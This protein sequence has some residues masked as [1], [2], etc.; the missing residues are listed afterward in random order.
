[1]V[2][3]FSTHPF[4]LLLIFWKNLFF[5]VFANSTKNTLKSISRPFNHTEKEIFYHPIPKKSRYS[6]TVKFFFQPIS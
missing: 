2:E 1:M 3:I 5:G 4:A 6:Q